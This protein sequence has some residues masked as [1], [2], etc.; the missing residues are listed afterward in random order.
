MIGFQ[1]RGLGGRLALVSRLGVL[2]A[3]LAL[4]AALAATGSFAQGAPQSD[5]EKAFYSIGA[6]LAQQLDMVQPISDRE[7]DLLLQ[8]VRDSVAGS[9]LAV[10]ANEGSAYVKNLLEAR[11]AKAVEI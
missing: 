1:R 4:V 9:T 3:S 6:S 5:D 8:G 2:T 11:Q 7:L 10:D